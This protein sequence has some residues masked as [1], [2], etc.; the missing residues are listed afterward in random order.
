MIDYIHSSCTVNMQDCQI[1]FSIYLKKN[2]FKQSY[3]K[4]LCVYFILVNIC[5]VHFRHGRF[6]GAPWQRKQY[7]FTWIVFISSFFWTVSSLK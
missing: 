7:A 3:M 4:S 1:E 6:I 5:S 2:I